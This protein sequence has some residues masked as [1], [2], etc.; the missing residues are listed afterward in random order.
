MMQYLAWNML[1]RLRKEVE[2]HF[3]WLAISNFVQIGALGFR[4]INSGSH[5][6]GVWMILKPVIPYNHSQVVGLKDV[7]VHVTQS[8]WAGQ[9]TGSHTSR[10]EHLMHFTTSYSY[11]LLLYEW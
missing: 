9:D 7:S 3:S 8:D 11:H 5:W 10:G 4:S 2:F 6:S 1:H